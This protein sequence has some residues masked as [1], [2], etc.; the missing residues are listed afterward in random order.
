MGGREGV[1]KRERVGGR[2]ELILKERERERKKRHRL[3]SQ[4]GK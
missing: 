3:L 1:R 4:R 2:E